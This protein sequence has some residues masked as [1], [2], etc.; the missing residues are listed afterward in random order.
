MKQRT[1]LLMILEGV[2]PTRGVSDQT[3]SLK[4]LKRHLIL[5]V[6]LF[7]RILVSPKSFAFSQVRR[8]WIYRKLVFPNR[9]HTLKTP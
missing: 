7:D 2:T 8:F 3:T 4:C 6:D 1:P 9:L 5:F